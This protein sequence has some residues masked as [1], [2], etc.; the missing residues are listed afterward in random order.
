[1]SFSST[2][3]PDDNDIF[4]WLLQDLKGARAE[5]V[6][7]HLKRC[8]LCAQRVQEFQEARQLLDRLD[9]PRGLDNDRLA[10]KAHVMFETGFKQPDSRSSLDIGLRARMIALVIAT[11]VIV[12]WMSPTI[13][14]ASSA[15][16]NGLLSIVAP[17]NSSSA[18]TLKE[19]PGTSRSSLDRFTLDPSALDFSAV[20]PKT[21]SKDL[22]LQSSEAN[23]DGQLTLIYDDDAGLRV[24]ITQLPVEAGLPSFASSAR[25]FELDGI[26]VAYMP[27]MINGGV[28]R[29]FWID[30]GIG[31]GLSLSESVGQA[32]PIEQARSIV[33]QFHTLQH[34]PDG[35]N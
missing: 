16:I 18:P 12:I 9:E 26:S 34:A 30:G 35:G 19:P 33:Q 22:T 21:L 7:S 10:V 15:G 24:V 28:L 23:S 32:L 14:E 5:I 25:S 17:N 29:M 27:E 8:P 4:A 1:M 31:F 13:S 6:D 20:V 3:H 2:W 11:V